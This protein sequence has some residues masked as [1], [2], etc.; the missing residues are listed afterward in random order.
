M[1]EQT[2][3]KAMADATRRNILQ[4]AA[5]QE[6]SVGELVDCLR[7]PQSTVSRHLKVLRDA[8]LILDRRE[9]TAVLYAAPQPNG[10]GADAGL[11]GRL[12]DWLADQPLAPTLA[13]RL[14]GIVERRSAQSDAFFSKVGHRCARASNEAALSALRSHRYAQD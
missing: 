8:G 5:Q 13:R 4:L 11:Q 6:L 3:F 2:V 14:R 7:Q 1:D 10:N 9:G 12:V